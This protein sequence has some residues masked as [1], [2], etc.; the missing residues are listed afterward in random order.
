[1]PYPLIIA[2]LAL[3]AA[4]TAASIAGQEVAKR[5]TENALDAEQGRQKQ[6][7][8]KA[9]GV[10]DT[11]LAASG[12]PQAQDQID[13]GAAKRTAAY[14]EAALRAPGVAAPINKVVTAAGPAGRA[15]VISKASQ[16]AW[17]K[18]VGGSQA[19]LGGGQDWVQ[20][21]NIKNTHA[22]QDLSIIGNQAAGSAAVSQ[23]AE[24]PHAQHSGDTYGE[25]G[26]IL[27][28]AGMLVGLYG[29]TTAPALAGQSA[30]ST[31]AASQAAASGYTPVGSFATRAGNA[32]TAIPAPY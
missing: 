23:R 6:F 27:S 4:G 2:A 20:N 10:F 30:A 9:Q 13:T 14:Q 8:N 32:W 19:T 5:N 16:N 31:S 3:T 11:S 7:Q 28:S 1:M 12:E 24:I 29:A 22:N 21:Q 17:A 18:A 25:I 26:Q 15:D